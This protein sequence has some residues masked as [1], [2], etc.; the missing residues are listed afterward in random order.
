M[1]RETHQEILKKI[2]ANQ[3][4][5]T[6]CYLDL[7]FEEL[8]F[9]AYELLSKAI[10][11]NTYLK[12]IKINGR[13]EPILLK[14]LVDGIL[15]NQSIEIVS[16]LNG[17]LGE[18]G[19]KHL[20]KLV[21]N[22]RKIT[23]LSLVFC[24]IKDGGFAY[25]SDA[26]IDNNTLHTLDL[27]AN[28]ITSKSAVHLRQLLSQNQSLDKLILA[29]NQL[30]DIGVAAVST[31]LLQ[32]HNLKFLQLSHVMDD[33]SRGSSMIEPLIDALKVNTSLERL[34]FANNCLGWTSRVKLAELFEHNSTLQKLDISYAY[35]F[36]KG[37]NI[38]I[39]AKS[40]RKNKGLKFLDL[41]L[42]DLDY[43]SKR[44]LVAH[45]PDQLETLIL[46]END[47][48]NN[49]SYYKNFFDRENEIDDG[50]RYT[51]GMPPK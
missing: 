51:N 25:L 18:E 3:T 33:Y 38:S 28:M 31:G 23:R 27:N 42:T 5:F 34:Y 13:I 15:K 50:E 2:T 43:E 7:R 49:V 30:G 26:L 21:T 1:S 17:H 10:A 46:E 8:P 14:C 11:K 22:D 32:N 29:H 12:K 41:E 36:N 16:L 24:F 35:L 48:D 9:T 47:E 4:E 44:T 20:A 40:L 37:D 39:F 19:G 45:L 6:E